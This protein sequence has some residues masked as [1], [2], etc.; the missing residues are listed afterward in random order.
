MLSNMHDTVDTFYTE[1]CTQCQN[2][3][4]LARLHFVNFSWD[5]FL[6]MVKVHMNICYQQRISIIS[7]R[8]KCKQRKTFFN[9]SA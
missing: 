3:Q 2:C 5:A 4:I 6:F 8:G 7:K 1:F 9:K